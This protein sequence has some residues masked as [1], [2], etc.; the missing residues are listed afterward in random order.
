MAW[1]LCV[2]FTIWSFKVTKV[3]NPGPPAV[4]IAEKCG[5]S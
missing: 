2:L 1:S 3:G 4:D 5:G